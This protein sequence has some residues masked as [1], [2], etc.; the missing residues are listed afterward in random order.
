MI[1]FKHK[2]FENNTGKPILSPSF[3]LMSIFGHNYFR[4]LEIMFSLLMSEMQLRPKPRLVSG[5]HF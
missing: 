3:R 4:M 1:N 2:T 5:R